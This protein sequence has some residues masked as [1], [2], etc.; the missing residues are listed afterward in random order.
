M[1]KKKKNYMVR[2]SAVAHVLVISAESE[3]K[4]FEYA[5]DVINCGDFEMYESEIDEEVAE[6]RLE[7]ARRHAN[8]VAEDV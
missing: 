5:H 3:E 1:K 4:A 2:I 6:H 7:M 8:C